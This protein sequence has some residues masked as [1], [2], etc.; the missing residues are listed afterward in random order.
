MQRIAVFDFDGTIIHGDSVVA[1]LFYARKKGLA[2]FRHVLNAALAGA[3]YHL[4]LIGPMP[5]KRAAHAFLKNLSE[6]EREAFL[7][8]FAQTLFDRAR[9]EALQQIAEH[10]K[11]GDLFILCS[12]SGSCYMRYVAELLQADALLC[13]PC[14]PDG[15]P[16]GPNCRGEEKV[17]RV[18]QWLKENRMEN[19]QLVAG[20]GDTAGD[21][22]IL[23]QCETPVLVRPKKKLKKLLPAA[24]V[25]NWQDIKKR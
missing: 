2:G 23:R 20:Y 13:T 11:A 15:L 22:P 19:A 4:H 18:R 7:R 12:A 17:T 21:A 14:S 24:T 5:S 25:A 16:T 3:M 8:D 10:K 6:T 1:M 9:P